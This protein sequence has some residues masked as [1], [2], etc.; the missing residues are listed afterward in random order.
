MFFRNFSRPARRRL[1][2][3]LTFLP[4]KHHER[5]DQMLAAFSQGMESTRDP[6]FLLLLVTYTATRMGCHYRQ[7]LHAV[8]HHS[9]QRANLK[10]Q[11]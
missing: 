6:V 1:L 7:L 4:P 11:M 8:F 2:S 10:L 9:R 5:A 3:A